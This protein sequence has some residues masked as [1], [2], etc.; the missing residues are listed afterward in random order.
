VLI[1]TYNEREPETLLELRELWLLD[2]GGGDPQ[3]VV[4]LKGKAVPKGV[5]AKLKGV[6]TREAAETLRG[7]ELA[8]DRSALPEAGPDEYY[9]ADL[10]GLE[11]V[12]TEGRPLGRVAHLM[13]NGAALVLVVAGPDGREALVPFTEECVPEVD[14]ASGLLK[15]AEVPGL[16][17]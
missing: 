6:S 5:I 14:L 10:L 11:V 7:R 16:L 9:Q 1:A 2:P 12:T 4:G 17:D 15:V 13:E 8:V 3:A